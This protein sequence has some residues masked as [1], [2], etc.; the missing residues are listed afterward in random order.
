MIG[1]PQQDGKSEE[2]KDRDR[3]E[4]GQ[5]MECFYPF[6]AKFYTHYIWIKGLV[7]PK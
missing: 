5:V 6:A 4:P 2:N 3:M 1:I 7:K